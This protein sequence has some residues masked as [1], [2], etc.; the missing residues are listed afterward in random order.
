[1][2]VEK[3]GSRWQEQA[4]AWAVPAVMYKPLLHVAGQPQEGQAEGKSDETGLQACVFLRPF[5][6]F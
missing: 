5:F 4:G 3:G 6:S 1:M 2:E